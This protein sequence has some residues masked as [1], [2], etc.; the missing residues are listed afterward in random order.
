M[1][2]KNSPLPAIQGNTKTEE[3]KTDDKKRK[4]IDDAQREK[5][6]KREKEA[7]RTALVNIMMDTSSNDHKNAFFDQSAAPKEI[8]VS[9]KC[10]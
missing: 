8:S 2:S 5:Q 9:L 10:Y 1:K 3:I 4:V 6:V 7:F